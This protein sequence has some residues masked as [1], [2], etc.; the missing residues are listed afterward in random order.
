MNSQGRARLRPG[1]VAG[2]PARRCVG[3]SVA[4]CSIV[5]PEVAITQRHGANRPV[6]LPQANQRRLGVS[7]VAGRRWTLPDAGAIF[8]WRLGH[9]RPRPP[10][11]VAQPG[12]AL[13]S[14]RRGRRFK[15]SHPDQTAEALQWRRRRC[16]SIHTA[17]APASA[18]TCSAV[19]PP[20]PWPAAAT[21][22]ARWR[23]VLFN[24]VG[25]PCSRPSS[26]ISPLR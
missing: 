12:S 20:S 21:L 23:T 13:R 10:R 6:P 14:G 18:S 2:R 8:K 9:L 15:S 22:F 7:T 16:L 24:G 19:K 1:R 17:A 3:A 11:G 25:T 5:P 4:L 26:T